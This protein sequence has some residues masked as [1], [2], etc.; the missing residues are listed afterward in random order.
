MAISTFTQL[1]SSYVR[2]IDKDPFSSFKFK[3]DC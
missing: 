3:Q 2:L 1:L